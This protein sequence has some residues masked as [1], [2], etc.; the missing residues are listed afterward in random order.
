M[1]NGNGYT[2]QIIT[3][4]AIKATAKA[5]KLR[6]TDLIAL[7]P[8][9]DPFYAGTPGDWEL[10]EWFADLWERFG[11]GAGVHIRRVHYQIISQ[12][13]P[14]MMPNGEPYE[15]TDRCWGILSQASKVARYLG[16]VDPAAFVD[17]R[18]PDP[19]IHLYRPETDPDLFVA[20]DLWS[21]DLDLPAFPGV[22]GYGLDGY[23]GTQ[24]YHL[25]IWCEKSTMNDVLIPLCER[26]GA[27][28]VTGVGELSVTACLELTQ[29]L[30]PEHPARIFYVSDFD[31]AG[32]SMPVAVARKIEFFLRQADRP[33][34]V[35][36]APVVLSLDQVIRYRLPRTPIKDSERRRASFVD[37]F[38]AGAVELDAL[39]ALHP[40]ELERIL[41]QELDHYYDHELGARVREAR[42]RLVDDLQAIRSN[43]LQGHAE[44]LG[45]LRDEY[46]QIRA[47]F[48]DRIGA[49]AS[50]AQRLWQAISAELD[51]QAPDLDDYPI[52]MAEE[53]PA[54]AGALY[55]SGRDYVEQ[56]TH[57]KAF[58]GKG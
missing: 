4:E 52:P 8:Q 28:L 30:D 53:R 37:R 15:N 35:Q 33:F 39:E 13:P 19:Y 50:R 18:N 2:P 12:D 24:R 3:Y 5:H 14:V 1:S 43:V 6:V 46:E 56:I 44:E 25:E 51:R 38:G 22:P 57:Y 48:E 9:N 26:Y 49:Y 40:G 29:R 21:D 27:N 31:P 47:D 36:L 55:D 58:Q 23:E 11:Y 7:A 42:R 20:G 10:A 34:D 16:L 54:F 41:S 17:R 32:R 45:D